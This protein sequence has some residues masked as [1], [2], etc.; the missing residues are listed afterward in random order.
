MLYEQY[1]RD[2]AEQK[3]ND[4]PGRDAAAKIATARRI[5]D[6][7][8]LVSWRFFTDPA[9]RGHN[10]RILKVRAEILALEAAQSSLEQ[11]PGYI[12]DAAEPGEAVYR[13]LLSPEVPLSA[14]QH[15]GEDSPAYVLKSAM[16]GVV[17]QL[18]MRLYGIVPSLNDSL[19]IFKQVA[20]DNATEAGAADHILRLV[21]CHYVLWKEDADVVALAKQANSVSAFLHAAPSEL[22]DYIKLFET[23]GRVDTMHF[24]RKAVCDH[25]YHSDPATTIIMGYSIGT[26]Q[27][28]RPMSIE[29]WDLVRVTFWGLLDSYNIDLLCADF[30]DLCLLKK[31]IAFSRYGKATDDPPGWLD[32][33][34]DISQESSFAVLQGCVAVTKGFL[35]PR[36][37]AL[38]TDRKVG[39]ARE[40]RCY[41]VCRLAK[42]NPHALDFI[43]AMIKRVARYIVIAYDFDEG[44]HWQRRTINKNDDEPNPWTLRTRSIADGQRSEDVP[45][46]VEGS[47]EGIRSDART[48]DSLRYRNMIKNYY[49]VFIISRAP[50]VDLPVLIHVEQLLAQMSRPLLVR[51]IVE[52]A[53]KEIFPPDTHQTY[54]GAISVKGPHSDGFQLPAL[55]YEGSRI[56][57]WEV[58]GNRSFAVDLLSKPLTGDQPVIITQ[59]V[60][61]MER[62]GVIIP[63]TRYERPHTRPV[64]VQGEDGMEDLYF[65]YDLGPI[66]ETALQKGPMA[67]PV[68]GQDLLKFARDYQTTHVD[69]VFAKGRLHVH[70]CAWPMISLENKLLGTPNFCTPEG[71]LFRWKALPFDYPLASRVWQ[72]FIQHEMNRKLDFAFF[73]GTTFVVCASDIASVVENTKAL[74]LAAAVHKWKLSIPEPSSWTTDI[75]AL[76]LDRLWQGIK[77]ACLSDGEG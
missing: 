77:P 61:D 70:Y 45:W 29:C 5:A 50:N 31:L 74:G 13:S 40:A 7:R 9:D 63:L 16:A 15:L 76:R 11:N 25:V 4:G 17:E 65:H 1:K 20:S 47:V 41:L 51:G 42:N 53:I 59:V 34:N 21:L 60:A 52:K 22:M 62:R 43:H 30:G 54:L 69:A 35:G 66:D 3:S 39:S 24:I 57:S 71:H 14:L 68:T 18:I 2:E 75:K 33:E 10:Q 38:A 64:V 12:E 28:S 46:K 48:L 58:S 32:E 67:T 36:P 72:M 27:D 56:R 19:D 49:E 23:L 6:S 8:S 55:R 73:V 44:Q 26:D 37:E